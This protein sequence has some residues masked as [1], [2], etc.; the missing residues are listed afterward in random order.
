MEAILQEQVSPED[1]KVVDPDLLNNL[2]TVPI[3]FGPLNLQAS[4][5]LDLLLPSVSV[6]ANIDTGIGLGAI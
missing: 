4:S 6:D 2:Q 5:F 1:L 3:I